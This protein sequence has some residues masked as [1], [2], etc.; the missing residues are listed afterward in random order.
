MRETYIAEGLVRS[1]Y[2]HFPILA[3][4]SALAAEYSDCV[5]EQG[6]EFFW[7]FVDG[8][9]EHQ[10]EV[11]LPLLARLAADLELDRGELNECLLSGRHDTTWQIDRARG[12]AMGV[13]S[14][15]TIFLAY[16]DKD[17]E[18]VRLQFRGARDF[19][20]MSQILDAILRDIEQ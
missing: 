1:I 8:V 6:S 19:D 10:D 12:E 17:G 4:E 16:L 3:Q 13:Q 15:P 14:T 2:F 5:G 11:G 18:E 20:N 7:A 9:Y